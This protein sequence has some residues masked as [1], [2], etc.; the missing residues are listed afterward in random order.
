MKTVKQLADEIGVNVQT[1]YRRLNRVKQSTNEALTEKVGGTTYFTE[2]G[3]KL[4]IEC[5]T[6]VK[7]AKNND[8]GEILFLREQIKELNAK[9]DE[10]LRQID[11]LTTHA[12]NL[13]RLNENSQ[14]LLVQQKIENLPPEKKSFWSRL[15]KKNNR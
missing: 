13:S 10:L 1:V 7:Q 14:L 11:K 15:F 4:I 6:P 12:E 8:N 9:N 2:V 3:E 5:L